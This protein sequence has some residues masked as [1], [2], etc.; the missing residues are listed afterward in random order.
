MPQLAKQACRDETLSLVETSSERHGRLAS[1][2]VNG[3]VRCS[4]RLFIAYRAGLQQCKM[5]HLSNSLRTPCR[6]FISKRVV[7]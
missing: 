2:P 1:A 3:R 5:H 6:L 7:S 4:R